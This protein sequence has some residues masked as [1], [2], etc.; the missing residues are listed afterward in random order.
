MYT[1]SQVSKITNISIYTIRHYVNY[2]FFP[3][4]KRTENNVKVF[5][6]YDIRRLFMIRNLSYL[7]MSLPEIKHYFKLRALGRLERS[8]LRL[9]ILLHQ[10]DVLDTRIL[11][12]TSA[13]ELLLED[14]A[15]HRHIVEN[16]IE[17]EDS[18]RFEYMETT[19]MEK[20]NIRDYY[21][22]KKACETDAENVSDAIGL[23]NFENSS[24]KSGN[25]ETESGN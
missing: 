24:D 9:E 2:G 1:L 14:I 20:W 17:W 22:H 8:K 10:L 13:R 12:I 3:N 7:Q 6:D 18:P 21:L 23:L 25:F 19:P 15:Y 5:D 11:E 16:H 4:M